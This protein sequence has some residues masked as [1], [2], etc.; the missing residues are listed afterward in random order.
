MPIHKTLAL[1]RFHSRD[2]SIP[3][4]NGGE[5][6][7]C[8]QAIRFPIR[9]PVRYHAGGEIGWGESASIGS[10]GALFT[11]DRA[12]ALNACV[13][14]NIKWPVLLHDSVQLRLIACGT[15]VRTEPGRAE[16]A[17][18]KYEFRTCAPAFF[19]RLQSWQLPNRTAP[20]A[21]W[22]EFPQ[23]VVAGGHSGRAMSK[24]RSRPEVEGD[25]ARWERVFKQKFDVPEYYGSRWP[26]H[27]SPTVDF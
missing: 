10:K 2:W 7:G 22:P 26:P 5:P 3:R 18:G 13:E 25:D 24:N 6:D 23:P 9:V 1:R 27:S 14:L 11:T 12:L 15:I 16:L 20:G 4:N 8:R 19:E 17:I 21:G